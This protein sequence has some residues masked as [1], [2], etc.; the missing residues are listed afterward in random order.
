M[1]R[2]IIPFIT[3]VIVA[4]FGLEVITVDEIFVQYILLGIMVLCACLV[5]V[6]FQKPNS[7]WFGV[8]LW[9]VFIILGGLLTCSISDHLFSEP[10]FEDENSTIYTIQVTEQPIEK[11]N[12]VKVI[13]L[14]SDLSQTKHGKSL[15][16]FD[17]TD[18][19][20]NL[21]YGDILLVAT[22]LQQV[23]GAGNP[24]EFNY[25]RYL[26]F[27]N[28]L[29]RGYVKSEGWKHLSDG[30]PTLKRG[31]LRIRSRL[32]ETLSKAGLEGDE[33]SVAS[34]LILGYRAEL[35]KELMT[36]Y[37]GAGATHVL[38]VSGLHVGIV[39]VILN[40]LLRF[41]DRSRNGRYLKTFLLIVFL[42]G[43]AGLTGLSASVFRAAT[44]FSFVALGKA[45]DRNTNIFNTLAASA[46]CLVLYEPLI[47]MQV[48]FQLSYAAVIGIVFFQPR[49]FSLFSFNNRIGDWA[50]G[51][52]CV[53]ISAQLATFPLGLLYFHQFP[54][55]FLLSNL[56]V[57]PAAALILYLGFSLFVVSW[58]HSALLIFGFLLDSLIYVL[59]EV[60]T[61]IE[62][63]PFSVISGID[64]SI[65]ETVLI[66]SML[67]AMLLSI[68]QKQIRTITV[69]LLIAVVFLSLQIIEVN[70]QKHQSFVTIY[71]V[72]KETAIALFNGASVT[73][74]ASKKLYENEQSM[75]F[76]VRHHWWNRGV[77]SEKFIELNDSI[78][79][80]G[81][82][83]NGKKFTILNL[84]E[85]PS[86]EIE[87][88]N[89]DSMDF[90]VI[91][92][93]SWSTLDK[94]NDLNSS[95]IHLSSSLG[96][97][98]VQ[99]IVDTQLKTIEVQIGARG[100][101]LIRL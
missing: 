86:S 54:N 83:W 7:I 59:N 89:N 17:K 3:G 28:I 63:I 84:K 68:T 98:T 57:I 70:E 58:W 65:F 78:F 2:I 22:R 29:F 72:R 50:W 52:T 10:L 56:L 101:N 92:K 15:F 95:T 12:T 51:I 93:A 32:V 44:M 35:D 41:L 33:L 39:Y 1:L 21:E 18:E 97:R 96:N 23:K 37:A 38:A 14:V 36:A 34:A 62:K 40:F 45:I 31:F 9:P 94:L 90:A 91:H 24:N 73:F 76:H 5:L 46:F 4:A 85:I 11:T 81:L 80:K 99:R 77:E 67:A 19:S 47:V 61:W 8:L 71:N 25:A 87:I 16:Y 13:G 64:I 20:L 74:I 6:H 79:N 49:L 53:S 60:V 55:L 82:N 30:I 26:R 42:F 66:Y 48:G 75:L 69:S 88:L 27:H 100:S 43:Y